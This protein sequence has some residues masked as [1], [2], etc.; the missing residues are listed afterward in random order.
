MSI[1]HVGGRW[2]WGN[3]A[4]KIQDRKVTLLLI[5]GHEYTW[6]CCYVTLGRVTV[7]TCCDA[8]LGVFKDYFKTSKSHTRTVNNSHTLIT[9]CQFEEGERQKK[10]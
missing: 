7:S 8:A 2:G 10:N 1:T 3:R 5:H 9:H 6:V 4:T